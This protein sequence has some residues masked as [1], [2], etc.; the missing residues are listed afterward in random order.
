MKFNDYLVSAYACE[1]GVGS[2]SE[3][4]WQWVRKISKQTTK[5]TVITRL[6]NKENIEQAL[7]KTPLRNTKFIYYDLPYIL[8]FYKK[9]QRFIN[10]YTYL[11]EIGLFFFL[12]RRFKY[13]SFEISQR[14]TFVSYKFPSFLWFF[15]KKFI[16]G[17]IAGGERYPL[18][19]LSIFSFEGKIKELIRF[20]MQRLSLFD[21]LVLLTLSNA[22]KIICVSKDTK[23]ILPK[24]FH[25]KIYIQSAILINKNDF[26][27]SSQK[28]IK[29]NKKL[30]LLYV[31]R[32]LEWKG[33]MLT[34]NALKKINFDYQFTLIGEGPDLIKFIN[35]SKKNNLNTF[36]LKAMD[37]SLLSRF[38]YQN[39]VFVFMSFRDSGGMALLE[40]KAHKLPCIVTPF[41]GPQDHID[42]HD[43][44]V[45]GKTEEELIINLSKLLIEIH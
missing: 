21:P 42:S 31:G 13:R 44:I 22:D 30:N 37:R 38:Y 35:F 25:K 6:N 7:I 28:R 33:I 5:L 36:F 10:L 19:L 9:G 17:P 15:S 14:I 39:D 1:P 3:V 2:E 23:T 45:E 34:L 4:G 26:K 8:K 24:F 43:Y 16:L 41:G 12:I 20:V 11:W 40:A 32:M 18:T 27:F 29:K